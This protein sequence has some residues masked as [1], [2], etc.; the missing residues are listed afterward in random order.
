MGKSWLAEEDLNLNYSLSVLLDLSQLVLL[1]THHAGF[2][3]T[4]YWG[5]LIQFLVIAVKKNL[6]W[7]ILGFSSNTAFLL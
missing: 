1:F 4:V 3:G 5:L 2:I 6:Q 7:L